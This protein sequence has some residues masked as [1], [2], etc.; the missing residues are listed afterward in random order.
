[1]TSSLSRVASPAED[2]SAL[3]LASFG[4]FWV[5]GLEST[6]IVRVLRTVFLEVGGLTPVKSGGRISTWNLEDEEEEL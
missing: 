4:D 1:M 6:F 2:A 3:A 5:G